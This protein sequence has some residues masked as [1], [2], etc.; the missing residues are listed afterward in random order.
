MPILNSI[1]RRLRGYR[2]RYAAY[3][4]TCGVTAIPDNLLVTTF[5]DVEGD[6]A[7]KGKHKPCFSALEKIAQVEEECGIKSTYNVV[8]KLAEESPDIF[9][10][11]EATGHEIAS[12]SLDHRVL[13]GLSLSDRKNS[14]YEAKS[15]FDRLGL[16]VVGHRSPQSAWDFSVVKELADA[17]YQWNAEDDSNRVP[18]VI[19]QNNNTA[20][21]LWRMP[22]TM[23]DW[24][25][26]G[27]GLSPSEVLKQ[28]QER[29]IQ[30]QKIGGC[31]S[32][33]FHPW[34][35]DPG[36]RFE[37]FSEF[38]RWLSEREGVKTMPFNKIMAAAS[39]A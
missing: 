8:A 22:V 20:K 16:N 6:Y 32:I 35:E 27:G 29:I 13:T 21:K 30:E 14:I 7:I 1:N 26:E 25:Y 24:W 34:V 3:N 36:E 17:G 18:Y 38:M 12:H 15:I 28:W 33:G 11:L 19:G 10:S 4:Q 37:V 5:Y 9:R 31:I 23:D 39:A 2:A